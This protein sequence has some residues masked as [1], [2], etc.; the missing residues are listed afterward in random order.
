M[1]WIGLLIALG[2]F[3]GATGGGWMASTAGWGLPGMLDEPV[4]VREQSV[5][6]R[7]HR[8]PLFLYFGGTRRHAGGGFRGG[9]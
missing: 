3:A 9:K 8:G 4:S 5:S 2:I 7:H 1:K 6:G